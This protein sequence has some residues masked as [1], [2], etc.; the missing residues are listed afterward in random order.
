VIFVVMML[1]L[2]LIHILVGL[3]A[4]LQVPNPG[5]EANPIVYICVGH[6]PSLDTITIYG[7]YDVVKADQSSW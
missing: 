1:L 6:D 4:H 5:T 7:H 3:D 2:L